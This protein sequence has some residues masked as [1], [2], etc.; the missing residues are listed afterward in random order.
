MRRDN[1]SGFSLIEILVVVAIIGTL[2]GIVAWNSFG[3]KH[4]A[5]VM[6]TRARM[7]TIRTA[8]ERYR[9]EPGNHGKY[10]SAGD[11]L[12]VLTQAPPNRSM[13]YLDEE[14]IND[15]WGNPIQYS[16]PGKNG[17][18]YDLVSWGAD[19][20]SGGEKDDAD[21]SLWDSADANAKKQP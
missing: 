7:G 1:R 17:K 9:M 14:Q 15:A 20:A 4:D 8:L 12:K 2:I 19:G 13:A 18:P 11:G 3:A 6:A 16:V 21:L 10:P 5:D